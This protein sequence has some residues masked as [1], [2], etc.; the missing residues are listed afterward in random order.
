MNI[1][2]EIEN[3]LVEGKISLRHLELAHLGYMRRRKDL[4]E[5]VRNQFAGSN[6]SI[7]LRFADRINTAIGIAS[8]SY[9]RA[10][11]EPKKTQK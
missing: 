10:L 6:V 3:Q 1:V 8:L 9:Y 5:G 2:Q 7:L 11:E 4:P